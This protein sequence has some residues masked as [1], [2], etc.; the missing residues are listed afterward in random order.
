MVGLKWIYKTKTNPDGSVQKYKARLM[1]KGYSQQPEID[2]QD[3]FIP[4]ARHETIRILIALAAHKGW[5]LYQLD[6]KSAFL[7]GVLKEE[8]YVVQ[9]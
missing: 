5:K 6:V 9:P 2:Y 3:T 7:N 4:V 1:A 8:V